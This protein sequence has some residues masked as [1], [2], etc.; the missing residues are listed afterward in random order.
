MTTRKYLKKIFL[1]LLLLST[2]FVFYLNNK[3]EINAEC[4]S[5]EVCQESG[6]ALINKWWRSDNNECVQ[7]PLYYV[8]C[9][10]CNDISIRYWTTS[11]CSGSGIL[12]GCCYVP[13]GPI[14]TN[15]T[16]PEP[17]PCPEGTSETDTGYLATTI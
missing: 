16:P 17:E 12:W 2:F 15:C 6:V 7:N 13:D 9:S 1:L 8:N 5:G 11:A 14:C 4:P 10:S 3:E